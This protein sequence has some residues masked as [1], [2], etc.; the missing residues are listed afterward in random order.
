[1]SKLGNV[2]TTKVSL[3]IPEGVYDQYSERAMKYGP[4]VEDELLAR[5]IVCR[6]HNANQAIYLDDDARKE[7]C[8]ITGKLIRNADD[9]LAWA[10]QVTALKVENVEVPLGM[11]LTSRLAS[12]QFGTPWPEHVRK[13]VLR[14]LESEVGLR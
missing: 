9:L 4:E 11:T 14:C 5:L 7:L 10:K 6:N 12:R 2:P 3:R 13:T 1:M 8:N